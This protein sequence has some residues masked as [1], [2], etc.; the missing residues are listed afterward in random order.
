MVLIEEITSVR[1][2]LLSDPVLFTVSLVSVVSKSLVV[3]VMF[4]AESAVFFIVDGIV[5]SELSFDL[6]SVETRL[7]VFFSSES[8]TMLSLVG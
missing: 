6:F 8:E 2:P 4:S 3:S 5:A 7:C 1:L